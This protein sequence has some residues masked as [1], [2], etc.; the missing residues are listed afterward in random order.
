MRV[1]MMEQDVMVNCIGS[2]RYIKTG[3]LGQMRQVNDREYVIGV[4]KAR[5]FQLS[6]TV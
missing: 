5:L 3:M 4:S 2:T 1:Q 6:E